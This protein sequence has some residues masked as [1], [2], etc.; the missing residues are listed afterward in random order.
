MGNGRVFT[1][2]VPIVVFLVSLSA[3]GFGTD[4]ALVR[5]RA[6]LFG[7]EPPHRSIYSV[8]EDRDGFLWIGTLD[9]LGRYDGYEMLVFRHDPDDPATL[10][11]N[12]IH[13]L[14]EDRRGVLW[15]GTEDGLDSLDRRTLRFTRH[16][17]FELD[18]DGGLIIT[19][20]H[21]DREGRLWFGTNHGLLLHR[22]D[23]G[24]FEA[25]KPD[26]DDPSSLEHT[27]VIGIEEDRNGSLWMATSSVDAQTV[28]RLDPKRMVFDRVAVTGSDRWSFAFLID[29]QNR[30]WLH[31]AGPVALTTGGVDPEEWIDAG[32]CT[33]TRVMLE[34]PDGML[35]I[36]C[37]DGLFEVDPS[38]KTV[39]RQLLVEGDEAYL[40]NYVR[41][42]GTGPS[43]TLWVGTQGG[44]F[45]LDP[46]AK[47][48][49][50]HTH[51]P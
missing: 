21:E 25:F 20:G 13:V 34:T 2:A 12:A 32:L 30:G 17:V 38:N 46:N 11:N 33:T 24:G 36:G 45:R 6:G 19:C 40:E 31:P 50:H 5:P 42:L 4:L 51:R 37:D 22:P 10:S 26:P 18:H 23:R 48:F 16:P 35:W 1:H 7:V 8:I 49:E 41:A 47:L 3:T 15:V 27:A 29:A 44:L 39:R 43:G 9:G 28:H 14:L